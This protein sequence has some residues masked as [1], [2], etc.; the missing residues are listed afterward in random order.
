MS[1][2]EHIKKLDVQG[3]KAVDYPIRSLS[4]DA[5]LTVRPA[6][7]SNSAYFNASL[8]GSRKNVRSV[9]NGS[10]TTAML[11]DTRDLDRELYARHIIVGWT[12]VLDSK[13]KSVSYSLEKALELMA[14]L[15]NWMFDDLRDFCGTPGN[16]L[17]EDQVDV[18]AT[19]K[20]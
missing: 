18:E 6:L 17:S 9:R 7:D 1:T 2:F 16:F 11:N 19:A 15:P 13:G 5:V 4:D 10:L 20:N 12:G 14:A 8:K 3:T